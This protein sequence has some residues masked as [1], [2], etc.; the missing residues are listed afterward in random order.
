MCQSVRS[1]H[2][3]LIVWI[4]IRIHNT[5]LNPQSSLKRIQFGSGSTQHL[6]KTNL[7]ASVERLL[8]SMS[9]GVLQKLANIYFSH[10]FLGI[11]IPPLPSSYSTSSFNL[12]KFTG[13]PPPLG[14]AV[15]RVYRY[16]PQKL[17][18]LQ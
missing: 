12:K 13:P 7:T 10:L 2:L 3:I 18:N 6:T 9:S 17:M 16:I 4:R 5:D 14:I 1:Y 15:T 11:R 8:R